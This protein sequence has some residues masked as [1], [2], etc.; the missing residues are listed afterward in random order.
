[1]TC[2]YLGLDDLM[3]EVV[4]YI[5]HQTRAPSPS[6]IWLPLFGLLFQPLSQPR[7]RSGLGYKE[8]SVLRRAKG[9]AGCQGKFLFHQV[10]LKGSNLGLVGMDMDGHM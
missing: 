6:E 3:G 1:M 10:G 2:R 7:Q 8:T 9:T 4:L 5:D